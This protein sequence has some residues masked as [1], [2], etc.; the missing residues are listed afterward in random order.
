MMRACGT[1]FAL[2]T[3][4]GLNLGDHEE[5]NPS[6]AFPDSRTP[7]WGRFVRRLAVQSTRWLDRCPSGKTIRAFL[8]GSK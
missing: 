7:S 8:P 5:K 3:V 6:L 4:I 2:K 1:A